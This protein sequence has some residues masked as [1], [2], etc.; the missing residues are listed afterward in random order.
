MLEE[1]LR[2]RWTYQ[3]LYLLLAWPLTPMVIYILDIGIY[4]AIRKC[5]NI[6]LN[7]HIILF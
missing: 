2:F 5:F 7:W 1:R 4:P 6:G 3:L